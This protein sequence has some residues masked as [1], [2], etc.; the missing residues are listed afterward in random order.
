LLSDSPAIDAGT[1]TGAPGTD[2]RGVP[3]PRGAT[4]D[5]GSYEA[6]LDAALGKTVDDTTP[7]PGQRITYTLSVINETNFDYTNTVVS[8][9][10]SGHLTFAGPV[11]LEPF[12]PGATL[13]DDA[14]DLPVLDGIEAQL[15]FDFGEG[16]ISGVPDSNYALLYSATDPY[17][18]SN[19]GLPAT[20]SNNQV[21]F[22][23]P[24]ATLQDGYYTLG[25]VAADVVITKSA[26]AGLAV[27]GG[28]ITYTLAFSNAGLDTATG[29]VIV[30]SVPVSVTNP[31]LVGSSGAVITQIGSAPNFAWNVQNLAPGQGGVIT[32]TG[33]LS[34]PLAAGTFTNTATITLI[35]TDDNLGNNSSG[36]GVLVIDNQPPIF[37]NPASALIT[38]TQGITVTTP[39]PLF[40]WADAT[41]NEGVVG[42]TLVMTTSGDSL[43]L[44]AVGSITVAQ[45][46]YTPANNL[47]NGV[48]TWTV[49]AYDAAG[50]VSNPVSPATF[51]L[52]VGDSSS[53][54][55]VYL[56]VVLRGK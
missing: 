28:T 49:S 19:T 36:I 15:S 51:V 17:S 18:F 27:P 23:V 9:T 44:Q 46:D 50:N 5:I 20:V 31:T 33:V 6:E 14:G 11:T 30:D 32:L 37:S 13:A 25:R 24:N 26:H 3:R 53:G 41:D 10:L 4:C 45:S 8:D 22:I 55:R 40:D 35:N 7:L 34:D 29:V 52:S 48:Y 16:G 1:C 2:Q 54:H 38:P 39:R 47:P 42:Y 43:S 12:Q 56:P 21:Q